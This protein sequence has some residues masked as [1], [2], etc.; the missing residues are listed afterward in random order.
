VELRFYCLLDPLMPYYAQEQIGVA[1]LKRACVAGTQR[2]LQTA[3][4]QAC[5]L[6]FEMGTSTPWLMEEFQDAR[7]VITD[8]EVNGAPV[9]AAENGEWFMY[10]AGGGVY[11]GRGGFMIIGNERDSATG[12]SRHNVCGP[13]YH[14]G[15]TQGPIA[16]TQLRS[17]GWMSNKRATLDPQYTRDFRTAEKP[18]AGWLEAPDVR[19]TALHGLDDAEPAMVAALR[20]LAALTEHGA[21]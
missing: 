19:V 6:V 20:L 3:V 9:W 12:A 17:K 16:P 11:G 8:R 14:S 2:A 4:A 10:R 15:Q 18:C 1:L 21:A 5:V 13:I 7:Y